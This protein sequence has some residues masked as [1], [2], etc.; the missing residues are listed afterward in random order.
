MPPGYCFKTLSGPSA[1]QFGTTNGLLDLLAL[2]ATK[3]MPLSSLIHIKP[4]EKIIHALRRHPI[5]F[6]PTILLFLALILVPLALYIMIINMF[7]DWLYGPISYP[8][9]VLLASVYYLSICLFFYSYFVD[10]YLDMWIITNDRL[11]DI[12][13]T[14]LFART[15]AEVDL[16]Q[17]QDVTSDVR[18]FFPSFFN[19][20]TLSLQT[21]GTIPKFI[22]Y[23]IPRPHK[24]RE[25]ILALAS[26]DKKYHAGQK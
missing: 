1:S 20:G 24:L 14:G 25:E 26:E 5:T 3:F 10:F 19:Y 6:L 22:F 23:N 16:Y 9:L 7:P 8:M 18:G 15:I 11:I 2:I 21:A 4:Y 17:I 13:Q 12:E